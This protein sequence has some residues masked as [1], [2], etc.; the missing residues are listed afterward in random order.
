MIQIWRD[1]TS[2]AKA[3]RIAEAEQQLELCVQDAAGAAS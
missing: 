1:T 2:E 3:A